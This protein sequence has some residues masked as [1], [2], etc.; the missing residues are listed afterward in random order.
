M[1]QQDRSVVKS[2]GL[3][4]VITWLRILATAARP[5]RPGHSRWEYELL[6]FILAPTPPTSLRLRRSVK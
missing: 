5:Q 4:T 3:S 6:T 1:G 2:S